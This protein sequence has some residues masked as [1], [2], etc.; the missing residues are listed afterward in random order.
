[1]CVCVSRFLA[2]TNVVNTSSSRLSV[3]T[4]HLT[5]DTAPI[6]HTDGDVGDRTVR[7]VDGPDGGVMG[8]AVV[9]AEARLIL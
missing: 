5:V 1:M 2:S 8:G 9:V 7:V 6:T 4:D 3:S